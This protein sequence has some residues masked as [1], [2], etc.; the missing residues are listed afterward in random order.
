MWNRKAARVC[1]CVRVTFQPRSL[2]ENSVGWSTNKGGKCELQPAQQPSLT[3]TNI[4]SLIIF[5][6]YIDVHKIH[7]KNEIL[8]PPPPGFLM[9]LSPPVHSKPTQ[10]KKKR[11]NTCKLIPITKTKT[12][13]TKCSLEEPVFVCSSGAYQLV[14]QPAGMVDVTS[15]AS[16]LFFFFFLFLTIQSTA[17]TFLKS[18]NKQKK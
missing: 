9:Q 11:E 8:S 14:M 12:N 10:K 4:T 3:I 17:K 18:R 7:S 2:S 16:T 5:N 15:A 6:I 13:K 1:V